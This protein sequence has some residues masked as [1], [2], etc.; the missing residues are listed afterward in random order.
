V[1][2]ERC[3]VDGEKTAILFPPSTVHRSPSTTPVV[4][5]TFLSSRGAF[6]HDRVASGPG[7]R[8]LQLWRGGKCNVEVCGQG[9]DR[10]GPRGGPG[11]GAVPVVLWSQPPVF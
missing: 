4:L 11:Q 10:R 6:L 5:A 1:D 2:G 7:F 8:L 3:T 9:V